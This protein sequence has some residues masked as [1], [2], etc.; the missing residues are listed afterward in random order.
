MRKENMSAKDEKFRDRVA[1]L[2]IKV[3]RS[4]LKQR[5]AAAAAA[6]AAATAAPPRPGGAPYYANQ[7]HYNAKQPTAAND[8]KSMAEMMQISVMMKRN[9][10]TQQRHLMELIAA[11]KHSQSREQEEF[12]SDMVAALHAVSSEHS[13]SGSTFLERQI[14]KQN[15]RLGEILE[16]VVLGREEG[17]YDNAGKSTS[18]VRPHGCL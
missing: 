18:R 5:R 6:A 17:R 3:L 11:E 13:E 12:E 2:K 8:E 7:H 16:E 1:R 10:E 14:V 4:K 15:E 9:A